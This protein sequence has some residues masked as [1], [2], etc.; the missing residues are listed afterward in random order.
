MRSPT[1]RCAITGVVACAPMDI[2][3]T[4][5]VPTNAPNYLVVSPR[6]SDGTRTADGT[7]KRFYVAVSGP[8][9]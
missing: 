9:D 4:P 1:T 2:G 6:N 7:R 8:R 3:V 5:N